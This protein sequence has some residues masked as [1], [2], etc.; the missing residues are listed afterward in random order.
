MVCELSL[1]KTLKNNSYNFTHSWK[2]QSEKMKSVLEVIGQ[3]F[4]YFCTNQHS[5]PV[6]QFV[7]FPLGD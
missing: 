7:S 4:Y 3:K 5:L 6:F 2:D 1:N